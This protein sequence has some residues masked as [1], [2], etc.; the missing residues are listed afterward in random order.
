MKNQTN[1]TYIRGLV[2]A[3]LTLL[4]SV[5]VVSAQW[6]GPLASPPG[7]NTL[8]PI[9]TGSVGQVKTGNLIIEGVNDLSQPYA[10][11][12]L[13]HYGNVGIG[14]LTPNAKLEV[15]TS[16]GGAPGLRIG[17]PN[18]GSVSINTGT[19]A[20]DN[21][22]PG[23]LAWFNGLGTRLSYLGY[24]SATNMN[25]KL[26]NGANLQISGGNVELGGQ[27]KIAGGAPGAGKVLT[28]DANGLASW[29]APASTQGN[30]VEMIGLFDTS[31]PTGWSRYTAL[32]GKV[33]RGADTYGG[34]G[35][36]DTHTHTWTATVYTL[37]SSWRP[38]I[39]NDLKIN[40]ASSW[41][42]YINMIWCKGTINGIGGGSTGGSSTV[43]SATTPDFESDWI[44]VGASATGAVTHNLGVS[45]FSK[46]QI[47]VRENSTNNDEVVYDGM[48]A[49]PAA[50]TVAGSGSYVH[51]TT[52]YVSQSDNPTNKVKYSTGYTSP[53]YL[54]SGTGMNWSTINRLG[55]ITS[56]QIKVRIWK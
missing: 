45:R 4:L 41:P 21:N 9:H 6:S 13:V 31:C 49:C 51:G 42:P 11:G 29:Q 23:Y 19:L 53:C 46:F 14:T 8:P 18:M 25:W 50:F 7:K 32:D 3:L 56:A 17:A 1:S 12:L 15:N 54:S 36:S 39:A 44:T 22:F 20:T 2:G 10:N 30:G 40:A 47:I 26:E 35:G 55:Y 5:S 27:I 33:P 37:D 24:D 38:A 34:T 43:V 52:F 48:V 28:S 16:I